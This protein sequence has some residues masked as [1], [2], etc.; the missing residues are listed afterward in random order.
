MPLI[1]CTIKAE[2]LLKSM[3][4]LL[5]SCTEKCDD[6]LH[7]QVSVRLNTL[8]S[9]TK[10]GGLGGD[11]HLK[12]VGNAF[13]LYELYEKR[14]MNTRMLFGDSRPQADEENLHSDITLLL[15][16]ICNVEVFSL[17]SIRYGTTIYKND[18]P[19]GYLWSSLSTSFVNV[20]NIGFRCPRYYAEALQDFYFQRLWDSAFTPDLL[21][22][23]PDSSRFSLS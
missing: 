1:P 6:S 23:L 8:N 19:W 11:L 22:S 7:S 18:S 5:L 16:H 21:P 14:Y 2:Y 9:L 4:P 20:F 13:E 12:L 15:A 17:T 10:A 3:A